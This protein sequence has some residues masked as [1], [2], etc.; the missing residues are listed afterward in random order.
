M[1]AAGCSSRQRRASGRRSGR[2]DQVVSAH[3]RRQLERLA[4]RHAADFSR[5]HLGEHEVVVLQSPLEDA[6][7][8]AL[9]GRRSSSPGPRR[10]SESKAVKGGPEEDARRH[11]LERR[12]GGRLAAY[13]LA[14]RP[15]G[16]SRDIDVCPQVLW[17]AGLKVRN[18]RRYCAQF[19]TVSVCNQDEGEGEFQRGNSVR[20][21]HRE[22]RKAWQLGE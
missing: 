6:A 16:S 9:R 11:R 13:R 1:V 5:G 12:A 22:G 17:G 4:D 18:L 14:R 10:R 8:V 21:P 19:G 2:T 3:Q 7:G 20:C 15:A